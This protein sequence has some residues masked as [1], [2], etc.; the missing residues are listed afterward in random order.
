MDTREKKKDLLAQALADGH[1]LDRAIEIAGC[2]RR[3]ATGLLDKP[4]FQ[5]L[6]ANLET[7]PEARLYRECQRALADPATKVSEKPK[8]IATAAKM[9]D[10]MKAQGGQS[11]APAE[12]IGFLEANGL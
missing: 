3:H 8:L 7:T 4:E 1:D 10:S 5:S 11:A 2:T 6:V 9:L 12:L